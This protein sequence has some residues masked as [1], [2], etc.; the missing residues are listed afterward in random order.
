MTASEMHIAVKLGLDKSAALEL[1]AFEPEEIDFWLNVAQE[2]FIK[3]RLFGTNVKKQG[4]EDSSKRISDLRELVK[5]VETAAN[6]FISVTKYPNTT[7]ISLGDDTTYLTIT[8]V[9]KANPGV[10]TVSNI[11]DL[12]NC[13]AVIMKDVVGMT[14][15]SN[16]AYTVCG[17]S[18]NTFELCGLDT[19]DYGAVGT[20]GKVYIRRTGDFMYYIASRSTVTRTLPTIDGE[21]VD[22]IL[23][24]HGHIDKFITTGFNSP[25]FKNPVCWIEE[26]NLLYI[27]HDALTTDYDNAAY[28]FKITYIKKPAVID[29][30]PADTT[31]CELD[32]STHQEIVDICVNLMIENVESPRF[33]TNIEQLKAQ[34]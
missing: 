8:G 15:L 3:Q 2:R 32:S 12:E 31:A 13:D 22:N 6:P 28:K 4:F 29:N 27:M 16:N 14:E 21:Y 5:D 34:E 25:Y 18:G 30:V 26:G 7:S 23:I 24:E 11:G 1:A 33:A 19:S 20:G 10:V 17:I 9:T